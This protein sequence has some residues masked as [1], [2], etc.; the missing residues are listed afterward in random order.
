[1]NQIFE[2]ATNVDTPLAVA[3]FLAAAFFGVLREL[4]RKTRFPILTRQ[5]SADIVALSIKCLFILTLAALVLGLVGFYLAIGGGGGRENLRDNGHSDRRY[6]R[7]ETGDALSLLETAIEE[8]LRS[9]DYAVEATYD[10]YVMNYV[11][12][13]IQDGALRQSHHFGHQG[14][15]DAIVAPNE[16]LLEAA[17]RRRGDDAIFRSL[18]K[19]LPEGYSVEWLYLRVIFDHQGQFDM[20]QGIHANVI[21]PDGRD[22]PLARVLRESP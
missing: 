13:F 10:G 17:L 9:L 14:A 22:R 16:A 4:L 2:I 7:P 12:S 19:T 11:Y 18:A 5:L 21:G 3:G 20:L 15:P 6:D 8:E 1:M